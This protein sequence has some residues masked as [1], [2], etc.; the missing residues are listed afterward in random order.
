M[1]A[2]GKRWRLAA[3]VLALVALAVLTVSCGAGKVA[4][5]PQPPGAAVEATSDARQVSGGIVPEEKVPGQSGYLGDVTERRVVKRAEL[6]LDVRDAAEASAQIAS[7][8]EALGGYVSGSSVWRNQEGRT[9]ARVTVRVPAGLFACLLEEI[10]KMGTLMSRQVSSTDVSEEYVDLEA[11]ISNLKVQETRLLEIA[12]RA[13]TVEDLLKVE[14]EIER[15]R[16][17][18]DSLTG[19]LNLLKNQT[20]YATISVYLRSTPLA[21]AGISTSGVEGLWG[22]AVRALYRSVSVLIV[23]AGR[24]FVGLFAALPYLVLLA[25][26][27]WGAWRLARRRRL[28]RR[29]AERP[30]PPAGTPVS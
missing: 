23:G 18:I 24:A 4:V 8:A 7:R 1:H 25:L 12:S 26:A 28:P 2:A 22:R 16:G 10:E 20:D 9:E 17:E 5:P 6:T 13:G 15:V 29:E 11:R 30:A 19:R 3:G 21:G 27:G 14:K